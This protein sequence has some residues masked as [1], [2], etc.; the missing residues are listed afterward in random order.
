MDYIR[1][2]LKMYIWYHHRE[3]GGWPGSNTRKTKYMVS[4]TTKMQDRIIIYQLLINPLKMWQSW[5]IWEQ[6]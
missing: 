2:E 6:Q 3:V 5:N 1:A 4:L